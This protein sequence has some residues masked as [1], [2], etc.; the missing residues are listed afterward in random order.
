MSVKPRYT[1]AKFTHHDT[2][3]SRLGWAHRHR[4]NTPAIPRH[5]ATSKGMLDVT[6]FVPEFI[7]PEAKSLRQQIEDAVQQVL[8]NGNVGAL[9]VM[10]VPNHWLTNAN[11]HLGEKVDV[12]GAHIRSHDVEG[13]KFTG[14]HN[15]SYANHD[16]G[17]RLG[18]VEAC[19]RNTFRGTVE[20]LDPA[21]G[22]VIS[23][24]L[25]ETFRAPEDVMQAV[26]RWHEQRNAQLDAGTWE[27]QLK[28]EGWA[29][30]SADGMRI[31]QDP[32]LGGIIDQ[33][34]SDK[35]W[36]VI[37][38]HEGLP[39]V[40]DFDTAGEAHAYFDRNM[41][42]QL[43][44]DIVEFADKF[45]VNQDQVIAAYQDQVVRNY[46][47]S[48]RAQEVV[49]LAHD[50]LGGLNN[51]EDLLRHCLE[52]GMS[53]NDL[54]GAIWGVS[55]WPKVR[56]SYARTDSEIEA[57]WEAAGYGI[58][59]TGGGSR[60][61][62]KV[63]GGVEFWLTDYSETE[64]PNPDFALIAGAYV[65][66]TCDWLNFSRDVANLADAEAQMEEWA[67]QLQDALH[68]AY[69]ESAAPAPKPSRGPSM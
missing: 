45:G 25:E 52:S 59:D 19:H 9:E 27:S 2:V 33:A 53:A 15:V 32:Q 60:A 42:G 4:S 61:A 41:A 55:D 62:M 18:V 39:Q 58:S 30:A 8:A 67:T 20:Y 6:L 14:I 46:G 47:G 1:H 64:T 34:I 40:D 21:S 37:F 66:D 35:K 31:K 49:K 68:E 56:A 16:N 11:W 26:V 36:F 17:L 3:M 12:R 44:Q 10:S 51:T 63:V 50:Q 29:Y 28:R 43:A 13:G 23:Q 57:V 5:D 7:A 38:H 69:G 65:P 54:A 22:H 24:Q 48:E